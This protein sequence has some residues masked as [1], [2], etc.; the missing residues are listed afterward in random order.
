MSNREITVKGIGKTTAAP[1][2]IVINM[3]LEVTESDYEKTMVL[4]II[5]FIHIIKPYP[6]KYV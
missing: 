2:L 4:Q 6:L 1:D 5:K 3:N